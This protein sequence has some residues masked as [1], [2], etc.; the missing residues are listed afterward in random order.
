LIE[1][2]QFGAQCGCVGRGHAFGRAKNPRLIVEGLVG[3]AGVA[4][5]PV[6][7]ASSLSNLGNPIFGEGMRVAI[8]D[9]LLKQRCALP[10]HKRPD[11]SGVLPGQRNRFCP[12]IGME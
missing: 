10:I 7:F 12:R 2:L 9:R 5:P 11:F 6:P 4:V 1:F 8:A 3:I